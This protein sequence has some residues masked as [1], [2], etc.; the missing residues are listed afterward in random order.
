MDLRVLKPK[1]NKSAITDAGV[2]IVE[3]IDRGR[4]HVN[5]HIRFV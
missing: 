1:T 5:A 3:I 2:E 4:K